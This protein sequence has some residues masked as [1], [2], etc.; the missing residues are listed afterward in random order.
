MFSF[1]DDS[2]VLSKTFRSHLI[3]LYAIFKKLREFKLHDNNEKLKHLGHYI[4]SKRLEVDPDKTTAI[5]EM[6]VPKNLK[7]VK[8]F[9]KIIPANMFMILKIY[10]KVLQCCQT[11]DKDDEERSILGMGR[12][13]AIIF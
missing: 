12:R 1:L 8:L 2:I 6:P 3:D 7:E 9:W 5:L 10:S 13:I 4:T 11:H